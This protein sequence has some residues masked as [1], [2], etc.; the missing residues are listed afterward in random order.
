[1]GWLV[2]FYEPRVEKTQDITERYMGWAS[3]NTASSLG[4]LG[5]EEG[6]DQREPK[7]QTY[8]LIVSPFWG[9]LSEYST[10][11]GGLLPSVEPLCFATL[12]APIILYYLGMALSLGVAR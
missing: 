12:G 6:R 11:V 2:S 4:G 1:M 3:R 10:E 7:S 9:I 5:V 8:M